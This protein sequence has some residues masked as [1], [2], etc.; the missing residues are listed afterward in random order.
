MHRSNRLWLGILML[1]ISVAGSSWGES[2]VIA[3]RGASAYLP[4]HTMEAYALAHGQGADFLEPD[5]VM[6]ADGRL[7]ALHDLT[8]EATTNVAE[9]FPDRA[10][11]DGG[12]YAIDFTLSEI[13]TLR[14]NERIEPDTGE[15]RY[16]ERWP[17]GL[18]QFRIVEFGELIDLT[19]ELNRSTG[20]R[21]GVYPELKFARF[22]AEHGMDFGQALVELLLEHDLP[23]DD[24]PVFI[25]S[26]EPEPLKT[27]HAEFGDQFALIQLIGMD[28]W[29]M[30]HVDYAAMISE[31]GL[32]E[33]AEFAVGIGPV[34]TLLV[35]GDLT[36]SPQPSALFKRAREL[37]LAMHPYTFRRE[38][39]PENISLEQLLDYFFHVLNIDGV[40]TDNPNVAVQ[41]RDAG[42]SR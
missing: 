7:I 40:F 26:F 29:Q 41:R 23:S 16:P 27:I 25:Q 12:F 5:L 11:D 34:L 33:V 13:R 4:E 37:G 24:L 9:R 21:V 32:A 14:V 38:G 30:N 15:A 17:V 36:G 35:D 6:T 2:L 3:H 1:G 8:L 42:A 22:H 39:L 20:Q 28:D 19:R 10:R 31:E 18:G